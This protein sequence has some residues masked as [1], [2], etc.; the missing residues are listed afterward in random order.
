MQHLTMAQLK[1]NHFRI[2]VQLPVEFL[3]VKYLDQPVEH[4]KEKQ[5]K[6]IIHDLGEGGLSFYCS[7]S[8]PVDM[9]IRL[10]FFLSGA[11]EYNEL[12]RVVRV[13]ST[14]KRCLIAIKFLCMGGKRRE[15]LRQFIAHEVK[16][17]VRII[18]YI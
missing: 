2:K 13:R 12:C 6:G 9:V 8:L 4:L 17:K 15:V 16:K 11:G 3:I 7:L 10:R 18:E 1:R 14:G 5:G